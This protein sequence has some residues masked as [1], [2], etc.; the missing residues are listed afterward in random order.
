MKAVFAKN[1]ETRQRAAFRPA[2]KNT[3]REN[4]MEAVS[5]NTDDCS[6]CRERRQAVPSAGAEGARGANKFLIERP[7]IVKCRGCGIIYLNPRPEKEG[8]SARRGNNYY[9]PSKGVKAALVI[10]H[11]RLSSPGKKKLVEKHKRGGRILDIGCGDGGFISSFLNDCRWEAYAL[12][13]AQSGFTRSKLRGVNVFKKELGKCRFP[14]RHFD[15]IT[16]WNAHVVE[17]PDELLM[18]VSRV[19]GRSGIFLV[20]VP[21]IDPSPRGYRFDRHTAGMMIEERGFKIKKTVRPAIEYPLDLYRCVIDSISS[22]RPVR[23]AFSL[24]VLGLTL[25]YKALSR[26]AGASENIILVCGKA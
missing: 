4:S 25:A 21:D 9:S 6:S 8:F 1:T 20:G 5:V 26:A 19:L 12:E 10:L 15:I 7:G 14:E 11:E 16:M 23:A 17:R 24:P 22:R 3:I 2:Q 18:E 13:P